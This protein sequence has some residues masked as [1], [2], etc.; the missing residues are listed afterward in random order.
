M[1]TFVFADWGLNKKC[2]MHKTWNDL[3]AAARN[4]FSFLGV[5]SLFIGASGFFKAYITYMLLDLTPHLL[6]CS[7]LFLVS[8]S[9]YSLNKLSDIKEDAVNMPERLKFLEGRTGLV[10]F[11]SLAAYVLSVVF[12][13]LDRPS[14]L[15]I[16][17]IPFIAN[18][19]YSCRLLPRI[20]RLKDI[21]VMK[22][23]M[24]AATWASVTTLLV[25]IQN[26]PKLDAVFVFYFLFVKSFINTILYDI[27][28]VKGDR[29]NGVRTIPVVLGHQL[30]TVTLLAVNSTLIIWLA[31]AGIGIKVLLGSMIIYG[32]AYILYFRMRRSSLGLDFFVD[33]EWMLAFFFLMMLKCVGLPN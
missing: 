17:S 30:T 10:L 20:P 11:Y 1:A 8:F 32:Y 28:D 4:I 14:A 3:L 21:P 29:D 24:V 7:A 31:L 13:L 9:V 12:I 27:R 23:L 33:G 15:H 2:I 26:V 16:L 5:S 18:V 6:V 25:G 19:A 22:N